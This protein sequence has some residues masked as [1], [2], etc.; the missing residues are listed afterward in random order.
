MGPYPL[1]SLAAGIFLLGATLAAQA[2]QGASLP[3]PP[4]PRVQIPPRDG[5]ASLLTG[6]ARIRG[7]VVAADTGNPLRRAQVR[8]SAPDLRINRVTTTDGDGRYEA[9]ELPQGRYS[10][11]VSRNGYV[12]LQFGQRRPFEPG[13]PLDLGDS[14]LLDRIDFALPRGGV[15]AGRVTDELGEPMV[16][17][18]MQAM[19]YQYLPSG[20]RQLVPAGGSNPFN[21]VSNDLGEFRVYGLMPGS[22]ILS[23]TPA[24]AAGMMLGSAGPPSSSAEND[25]HGITFYPGTI[26]SEEAQPITVG[27]AEETSVSF[28]LVPGRMTRISG[29]IRNSQGQPVVGV[30]LSLRTQTGNGMMSRALPGV[31]ADG[32]FTIGNVPPGDHWLEVFPRPGA[33][34][35]ASVAIT[36]AGGDI[37]NLVISTS[38]G[39]TIS[40][41]VIFDGASTAQKPDRIIATSPEPGAPPPSR[42]MQDSGII[43]PTGRFEIKGLSG[44]ALFRA[45]QLAAG[46]STIWIIRS[47]TL[48]G[49]DVTDTP[50]DVGRTGSASD[51]EIVLTDKQTTFSGSVRNARGEQVNDYAVAIFPEHLNE[52]ALP[53]RFT[54]VV[55]P[56]QQG[57]FET[58]GLPPGD[59]V[60]AAVESVEQRG[61]WDPA[62]RKQVEAMAKRFRLTEG[63]TVSLDL[64]LQ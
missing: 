55:R 6:T 61:E 2:P 60:A 51:L 45:V 8:V 36:A 44:R 18:R 26:S 64:Q 52:G 33:E 38:P 31:G 58:R 47:V 12:S 50:V 5:A 49:I 17:V 20:Q 39:V 40:G 30:M 62:F 37:T 34:E 7:R 53:T 16:G 29:V 9:A 57:R 23:A 59:Y 48:N 24:D 28:A 25:G 1:G 3:G 42:S 56:D 63:N 54:R 4:T 32:S 21:L 43:D 13:R 15:I 11:F 41:Q 14:Q 46:P 22:Y 35:S 27:L 10:I 19:R